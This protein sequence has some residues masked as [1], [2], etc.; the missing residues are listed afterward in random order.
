MLKSFVLKWPDAPSAASLITPDATVRFIPGALDAD[1]LCQ[2]V[3]PFDID[4]YPHDAYVEPKLD[5][6]RCIYLGG[7][8]PR[9]L[10]KEGQPIK[11]AGPALFACQNLELHFGRSMM[12]DGEITAGSFEETLSAFRSGKGHFALW[13]F[14]AVPL[15]E[16]HYNCSVVPFVERRRALAAAM[17]ARNTPYVGMLRNQPATLE[18]MM[19]TAEKLWAADCEGLVIKSAREPYTRSRKGRWMKMKQELDATVTVIGKETPS[20]LIC[21]DAEDKVFKLYMPGRANRDALAHRSDI[22]GTKL[23]ITCQG[24]TAGGLPRNPTFKRFRDELYRAD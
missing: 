12:F 1:E 3:Q 9:F 16:W 10:T 5:G 20:V 6:I 23:D 11:L 22:V 18:A 19:A 2:L 4:R 21:K 7:P 17:L 24:H 15:D 8:D 13:L 14:D